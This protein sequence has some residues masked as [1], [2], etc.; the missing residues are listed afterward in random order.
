MTRPPG[1]DDSLHGSESLLSDMCLS[2]L[3]RQAI[4]GYMERL[5]GDDPCD[6][7]ALVMQEVER[8]LLETVMQHCDGNQSRAAQC[9]GINRA[10]LRKKLR[11]HAEHDA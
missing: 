9:L 1:I 11:L 7:Y 3:V 4:E 5:E 2:N 8:P 6:L 10:T